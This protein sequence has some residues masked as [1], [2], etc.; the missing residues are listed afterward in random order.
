MSRDF[1]GTTDRI[2]YSNI[3]D[4]TASNFSFSCIINF[5]ARTASAGL[6]SVADSSDT[7]TRVE[8]SILSGADPANLKLILDY[9]TTDLNAQSSG[10]S[11]SD[12][13][14]FQ[15]GVQW[16]GAGRGTVKWY[17][18][19]VQFN[20]SGSFGSDPSGT[21]QS[22]DGTWALGGF[23]PA[24]NFNINGQMSNVGVWN[25]V[26]ELEEWQM[27]G[28]RFSPLF[29]PK[30]LLY[31]PDLIRDQRDSVSG[32]AGTLDGTTVSDHHRV[33]LPEGDYQCVKNNIVSRGKFISKIAAAMIT[34]SLGNRIKI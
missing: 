17:Q 3:S 26:L 30:G 11:L 28:D 32:R 22:A 21:V 13:T 12:G 29:I 20:S 18:D 16:G 6:F 31:A 9:D 1:N 23:Q 33:I 34:G 25:R 10:M 5:D 7:I 24:D 8:I 4:L 15:V 19:G 2:D 27:L 14:V